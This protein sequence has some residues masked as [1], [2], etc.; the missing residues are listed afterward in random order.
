LVNPEDK[1]D[2]VQQLI[3]VAQQEMIRLQTT[4]EQMNK[5]KELMQQQIN[6]TVTDMV[7]L[8]GKIIGLREVAEPSDS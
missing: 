8:D 3:D 5:Q 4:L 6:Q 2:R 7:R 1:K